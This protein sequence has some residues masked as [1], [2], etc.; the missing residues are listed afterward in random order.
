MSRENKDID[1]S[2]KVRS[3]EEGTRLPERPDEESK[4]RYGGLDGLGRGGG[5]DLEEALETDDID[6][7]DTGLDTERDKR[8]TDED[9]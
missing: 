4:G 1:P 9:G 8:G 6:P 3:G 5:S 7:E 2:R